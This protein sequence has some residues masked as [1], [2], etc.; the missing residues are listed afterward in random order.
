M[1]SCAKAGTVKR[2][3]LTSSVASILVRPE[4]QGDGH[5][6]DEE[7]WSDVERLTA[8][9]P[10]HRVR[11]HTPH[12]LFHALPFQTA[13]T[14]MAPP[15]R[16]WHSFRRIASHRM[17]GYPVSKVLLEKEASRFAE[18]HGISVVTVCPVAV[19]GAAPAPSVPICLSLLSGELCSAAAARA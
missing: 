10:L 6:L 16:A 3:V 8:T 17:Q 13:G 11:V 9:K 14:L 19:V 12:V 18:E 1:R 5:V 2:V 15:V 4:L 7:S